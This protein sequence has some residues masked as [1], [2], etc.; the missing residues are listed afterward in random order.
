MDTPP[1]MK[2]RIANC[3]ITPPH[4]ATTVL[5]VRTKEFD[6]LSLPGKVIK[7]GENVEKNLL[8]AIKEKTNVSVDGFVGMPFHVSYEAKGKVFDRAVYVSGVHKGAPT[9]KGDMDKFDIEIYS[10]RILFT[11]DWKLKKEFLLAPGIGH[12][13]MTY[14]AGLTD[15]RERYPEHEP[16]NKNNVEE[17]C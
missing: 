13:V 9:T 7:W 11:H 12:T 10:P 16:L 6:D 3:I 14:Y 5:F 4:D 17:F 15:L 8:I 1:C 2:I